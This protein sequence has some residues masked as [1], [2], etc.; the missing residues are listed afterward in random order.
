VYAE[1]DIV[2]DTGDEKPDAMVERVIGALAAVEEPGRRTGELR[3]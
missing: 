1:A 3:P 2:V